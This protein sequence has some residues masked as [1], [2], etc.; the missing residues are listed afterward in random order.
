M[1]DW[2]I[3]LYD[4]LIVC[5]YL[6]WIYISGFRIS[7]DGNEKDEDEY[8]AMYK[9]ISLNDATNLKSNVIF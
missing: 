7:A 6:D 5:K 8:A 2:L 1:Y 3:C 4:T 9:G